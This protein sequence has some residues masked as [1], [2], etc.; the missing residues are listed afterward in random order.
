MN[1]PEFNLE[2]HRQKRLQEKVDATQEFNGIVFVYDGIIPMVGNWSIQIH[3]H[4]VVVNFSEDPS[5]FQMVGSLGR[6]MSLL[7]ERSLL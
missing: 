6:A 1:E 7:S 3:E 4:D 2:E 5:D